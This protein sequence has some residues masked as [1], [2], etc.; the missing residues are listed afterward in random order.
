MPYC[1]IK[2]Q[3]LQEEKQSS[4]KKAAHPRE[5]EQFDGIRIN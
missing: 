1:T 5:D 4:S 2:R 3:V